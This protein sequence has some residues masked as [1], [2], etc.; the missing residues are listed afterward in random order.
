[1]ARRLGT[2]AA[3]LLVALGAGLALGSATGDDDSPPP[4]ATTSTSRPGHVHTGL[5]G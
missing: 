5:F 3:A 1:V 4:T 2:F